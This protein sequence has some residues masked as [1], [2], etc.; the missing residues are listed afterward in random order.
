M[1]KQ[2]E[3]TLPPPN[4][5]TDN[6]LAPI[7]IN[8]PNNKDFA[9]RKI[10][11]TALEDASPKNQY[12]ATTSG[13]AKGV[14]NIT[15]FLSDKGIPMPDT[16]KSPKKI[17]YLINSW[18]GYPGSVAQAATSGN[19]KDVSSYLTDTMLKN[20]VADPFARKFTADARFSSGV[21]SDFYDEMDKL[22]Q[23][24]TDDKLE[25]KKTDDNATLASV[26][27]KVYNKISRQLSELSK[28]EKE[29]LA[30]GNLTQEQMNEQ[31]K[32]LR[33]KKNDLARSAKAQ[34]AKAEKDYNEAPEYA[35]LDSNIQ[36]KYANSNGV[37]KADFARAYNAQKNM[38]AVWLRQ[39]RQ[40]TQAVITR[41]YRR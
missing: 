19:A 23:Q 18:G 28:Q 4:P 26:K 3:L 10:V 27:Y 8:L 1:A 38:M 14:S 41:H 2:L 13:L 20:T 30:N 17:D 34:A 35:A 22:N 33:N 11:P 37:S 16:I 31:I 36:A 6:I 25:G 7:A 32:V 15:N 29:I 39:Y 9:G 12:D 24:N 5:L 21:V 40:S